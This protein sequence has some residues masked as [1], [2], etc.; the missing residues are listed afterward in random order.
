MPGKKQIPNYKYRL[1]VLL[2]CLPKNTTLQILREIVSGGVTEWS[3]RKIRNTFTNEKW[4][5]D[6]DDLKIIVG[7]LSPYNK[8]FIDQI[9]ISI[10]SV[11]DLENNKS[12]NS[13]KVPKKQKV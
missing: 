9:G 6:L 7:I 1:T 10:S 12:S 4:S 3:L 11:T 5:A 8:V 13:N 2:G